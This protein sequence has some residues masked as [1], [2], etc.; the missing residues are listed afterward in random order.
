M[1]NI[2]ER[3]ADF[4]R[5]LFEINQHTLQE[6]AQ[7]TQSNFKKYFEMNTEF[8][9]KLPEVKDVTSFVELQREYGE[10]LWGNVREATQTQSEILKS[11]VEETGE[12]VRKVFT[13]ES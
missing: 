5:T 10:T 13:T 8:G 6:L 4:G 7:S 2:I 3:Q 11:A 9:Q 12:A 1:T